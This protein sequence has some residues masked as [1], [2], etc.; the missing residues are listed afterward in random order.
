MQRDFQKHHCQERS[1]NITRLLFRYASGVARITPNDRQKAENYTDV[2][3][4]PICRNPH[5]L[6]NG[7]MLDFDII[8]NSGILRVKD[9]LYEYVL[10]YLPLGAI[11]EIVHKKFADTDDDR[12]I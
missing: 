2:I 10:G 4:Q 1:H 8:L 9:M 5:I 11:Q 7:Q 6:Y 12:H 3:N